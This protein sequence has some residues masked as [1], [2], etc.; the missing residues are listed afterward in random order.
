MKASPTQIKSNQIYP[1]I[2]DKLL[3]KHALGVPT[4][5]FYGYNASCEPT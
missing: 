3:Q 4:Y 1:W 2:L 5:I